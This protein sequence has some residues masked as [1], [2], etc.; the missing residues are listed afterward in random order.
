MSHRRILVVMA[1]GS[2]ERFWPMSTPARPKQLLKLTHD[3]KS[4]LEEAVERVAPAAWEGN[5]W[6]ST[7]QTLGAQIAEA[8][9]VPGD[10]VI[11]EPGRR[12]T[13]GALAWVAANLI[14]RGFEDATVG[15]VTADHRIS[16]ANAFERAVVT[17][18]DVAETEGGLVTIGIV[19]DRPE[20]GYGYIQIDAGAPPILK[21]QGQA[22]R[23]SGFREKPNQ[24]LA[25]EYVASGDYLWNGGMFFYTLDLFMAEFDRISPEI[26][27]AIRDMAEALQSGDHEEAARRFFDLP[28]ISIDYAL[29]EHVRRLFVVPAEF[30]WDDVGSWDAMHR[31]FDGDH[32]G[33]VVRGETIVI[34]SKNCIVVNEGMPLTIGVVGLEGIVVVATKDGILVCPVDQAQRVKEIV[35]SMKNR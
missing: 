23:S 10:R 14:A 33:N 26:A 27:H 22:F 20:T 31:S 4:M 29:A 9:T 15:V 32:A 25:E 1:G 5:V 28:N 6:I 8:E 19:P 11:A 17:A 13:L 24:E 16:D 2:G 34:D 3:E 35:T 21:S 7:S 30:P 18:L 12:N